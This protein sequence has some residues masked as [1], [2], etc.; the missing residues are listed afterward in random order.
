MKTALKPQVPTHSQS[1]TLH[2]LWLL[3]SH[4]LLFKGVAMS[5]G[6]GGLSA[7]C[8]TRPNTPSLRRERVRR[9]RINK[10][11]HYSALHHMWFTHLL[12]SVDR[13][14]RWFQREGE[15]W[16]HRKGRFWWGIWWGEYMNIGFT[17]FPFF[18]AKKKV[19]CC[20][21]T[22]LKI[23]TWTEHSSCRSQRRTK[24]IYSSL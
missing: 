18:I 9:E 8:A 3:T 10:T 2:Y 13:L 16:V 4:S 14:W 19:L 22:Y 24:Y 6:P 23:N 12:F 21:S 5:T 7:T 11:D 17:H 20:T 1:N 15:R